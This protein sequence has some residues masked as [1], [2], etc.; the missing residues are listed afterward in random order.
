MTI[1]LLRAVVTV[2]A[3]AT[4]PSLAACSKKSPEEIASATVVAVKT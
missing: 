1:R 3:L 4:V 2:L